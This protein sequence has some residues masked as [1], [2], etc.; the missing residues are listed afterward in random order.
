VPVAVNVNEAL[1][2]ATEAGVSEDSVG[3]T[4]PLNP[5]HPENTEERTSK[6]MRTRN[7]DRLIWVLA[8][9]EQSSANGILM[10]LSG[11][12]MAP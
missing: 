7:R 4:T 2:A 9:L 11:R 5:P 3:V 1:P 6:D 8:F 12:D 10:Q